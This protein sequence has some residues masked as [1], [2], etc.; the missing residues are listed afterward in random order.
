MRYLIWS[1]LPRFNEFHHKLHIS[2]IS[3]TILEQ[4]TMRKEVSA[5]AISQKATPNVTRQ[6]HS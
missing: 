1:F 6:V 4:L 5:T 2:K 3:G